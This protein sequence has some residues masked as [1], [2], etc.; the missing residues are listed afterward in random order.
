VNKYFNQ[1]PLYAQSGKALHANLPLPGR[2]R[3]RVT[4]EGNQTV[5]GIYNV[6]VEFS[7]EKAWEDPGQVGYK[8]S[9]M[10]FWKMMRKFMRPRLAKLTTSDIMTTKGWRKRFDTI[11]LTNKAYPKM[12]KKLRAWVARYD[13]NLV[14]TD[15]A[16]R[17][18]PK[19]G[20]IK[21]GVSSSTHYAG[22][23]N[24]A[25]A[26]SA[27]T[28]KDL[29]AKK[30]NQPGAAEG[31]SGNETARRQTYEPVP[32]GYAIQTP[33]GGDANSSPVWWVKQK[34]WKKAVGKQ[35]AVGTTGNTSHISYGEIKYKGGRIRILGGVLPM[36]TQSFD[37]P[38]GLA[39]YSPTYS[40]YQ[41][42]KNMLQWKTK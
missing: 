6:G 15:A 35:R 34:A 25:T 30:I 36:P 32:L 3:V 31:A 17:M 2:W 4:S 12:A 42:L 21:R 38:F 22:Y 19:M 24:F 26:K 29:L 20:M 14:L 9:N 33:D 37:H 40:G 11:V 27:E 5:G 39:S 8:V 41:M 7:K 1:S 16:L 23:V 28:Y 13:G 10:D 18:L